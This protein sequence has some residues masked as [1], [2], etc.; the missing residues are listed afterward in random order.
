M[1]KTIKA[2]KG[3]HFMID[4]K[5]KDYFIMKNKEGI[6]NYH[7]D[8][9]YESSLFIEIDTKVKTK[10]TIQPAPVPVPKAKKVQPKKKVTRTVTPTTTPRSSGGGYSG[11][12]Y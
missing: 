11:G 1:V 12:G 4:Q 6:Y 3:F 8:G 9:S 2:P 7:K 10:K 5:T